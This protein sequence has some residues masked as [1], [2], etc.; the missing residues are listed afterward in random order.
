METL[1]HP[2]YYLGAALAIGLLIGVERGWRLKEEEEGKRIAG[3]RTF[4][5]IG[6]LGGVSGL[7]SVK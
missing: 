3:M 2:I 1:E 4:G 6:L 7:L 5:L